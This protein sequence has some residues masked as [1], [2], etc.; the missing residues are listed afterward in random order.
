[1]IYKKKKVDYNLFL[2]DPSS[3]KTRINLP[4]KFQFCPKCFWTNQR[5]TTRSEH[6][7]KEDITKTI[8]FTDGICEACKIKDK[9][10]TVD[11]D[12]R[13]YEFKKLLDKY[14]SRNGSYDCVVPGSGG[15]DSFYVSHRLKYEYGMNP[16]TVTFSPFMYTDWGFKNLKNWT[17]SGFENYLNIPNQKIYRLLSRLALE[18]IFHPWQPWILGQKNYP[19]KFARMMKVPLIIYGES[20]SEYGSPDS[21]YTSQYVKEWHTYK[22]LSD[23]HLSGCSLDELYSYGLKQYDLHPF[24]PLHEKEFEESE[25][26]CCAFSYFHKWHPQENYYYTIENS[27]FHVSP[28]RT[29]GTYSKYASID[30]KM[31]DMFNYTYFVK[32]GIGRTTHDVTQEIRNGDITLKEGANL[33]KKYD[34]EY[35]SRFDK[36]IFEY[37]SI[38]KEEF[39]EKISNLFES[40]TVDKEYFTDLSD[41]FRSPHLWKKTNKGFE[42]RNKIEDYFPQ[43]FEKNN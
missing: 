8:V 40:P 41:N 6:Y 15:K 31:D 7:V 11:W 35:P 18:K 29:A 39:G 20:P 4:S 13:K 26:N 12:K 14:R 38:P 17:N 37:F 36:E 42:L 28:E 9:K 30:D 21:E 43:Y 3:L 5:P 2:G 16:V 33:I 22:K 23:I 10:D 1:M 24:M 34:G 32:Y 19:T 27:S 25:L